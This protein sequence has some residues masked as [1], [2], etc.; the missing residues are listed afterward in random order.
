VAARLRGVDGEGKAHNTVGAADDG[1]PGRVTDRRE[2]PR[3]IGRGWLAPQ[4]V[5]RCLANGVSVFAVGS[6]KA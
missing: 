1:Q 6:T 2:R 3:Q 4:V 5:Y